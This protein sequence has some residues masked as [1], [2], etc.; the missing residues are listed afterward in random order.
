MRGVLVHDDEAVLGFGDDIGGGDLPPGDA[1][2]EGGGLGWR[3]RGRFGAGLGGE[4]MGTITDRPL[5]PEGR[6]VG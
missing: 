5:S 4:V 3:F 6:G 2:G 1:E